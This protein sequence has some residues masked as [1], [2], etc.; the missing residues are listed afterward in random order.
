MGGRACE[1]CRGSL[2]PPF[3]PVV[4]EDPAS[5]T[6]GMV[7]APPASVVAKPTWVLSR[8]VEGS[9][10]DLIGRIPECG[11]WPSSSMSLSSCLKSNG[12]TC[13]GMRTMRLL[14]RWGWRFPRSSSRGFRW[15]LPIVHK[16]VRSG[17]DVAVTSVAAKSLSLWLSQ[18]IVVA[19]SS[20]LD[21]FRHAWNQM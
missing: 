1:G 6:M 20:S 15:L 19:G 18:M 4:C 8:L 10:R 14:R 21:A 13:T 3:P 16:L 7:S 11:I 17:R 12:V 5:A 9:P 2:L